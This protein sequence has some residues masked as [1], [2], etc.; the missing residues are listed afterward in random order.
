MKAQ[1]SANAE[2]LE[3]S[4]G[5]GI[6]LLRAWETRVR[7]QNICLLCECL[8]LVGAAVAMS[9]AS[10]PFWVGVFAC[11]G[12]A[13]ALGYVAGRHA[14]FPVKSDGRSTTV[15]LRRAALLGE[16]KPLPGEQL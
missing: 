16:T 10:V 2:P 13:F 12:L 9:V 8:V 15:E 3:Q 4:Q 5:E 6:E 11:V 1:P 14:V 7:N